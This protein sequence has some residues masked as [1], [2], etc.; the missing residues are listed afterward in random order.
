MQCFAVSRKIVVASGCLP[1]RSGPSGPEADER[2]FLPELLLL[3][4]CTREVTA[5]IEIATKLRHIL[6]QP[7]YEDWDEAVLDHF[8][9]TTPHLLSHAL[10]VVASSFRPASGGG[11]AL[12]G[13]TQLQQAEEMLC[14]KEVVCFV[15]EHAAHLLASLQCR[16]ELGGGLVACDAQ[17]E[18]LT[19]KQATEHLIRAIALVALLAKTSHLNKAWELS[20]ASSS[21]GQ[22]PKVSH[23]VQIPSPGYFSIFGRGYTVPVFLW[24]GY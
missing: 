24:W 12:L 22:P 4:A 13:G 7:G 1:G 17:Q 11:S 3:E 15:A 21:R 5:F 2:K 14:K 23:T 20:S 18:G 8:F 9:L 6:K 10:T 16:V 19:A